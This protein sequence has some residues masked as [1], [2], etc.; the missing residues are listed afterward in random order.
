MHELGQEG[1][2]EDRQFGIEDVDQDKSI[3]IDPE[4]RRS[5]L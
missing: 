1:Q 3:T 4:K 5:R 2:K